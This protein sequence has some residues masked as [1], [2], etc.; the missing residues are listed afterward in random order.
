MLSRISPHGVLPRSFR[1]ADGFPF[2]ASE[3]PEALLHPPV[4]SVL[5]GTA[6]R[7]RMAISPMKYSNPR[8]S[9][10][11]SRFFRISVAG[12]FSG[13][14]FPDRGD[15]S[16]RSISLSPPGKLGGVLRCRCRTEGQ[17]LFSQNQEKFSFSF[18]SPLDK[19][20]WIDYN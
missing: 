3:F 15:G 20:V 14:V 16:V 10:F 17:L 13:S 12:D 7:F 4:P 18:I 19:T 8:D 9:L 2:P 5:S 1:K 6:R 11:Q